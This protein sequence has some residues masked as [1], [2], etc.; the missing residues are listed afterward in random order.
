MF[1][2]TAHQAQALS[3]AVFILRLEYYR[4]TDDGLYLH[5]ASF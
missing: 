1:R 3:V 2:Q 5:T 4:C